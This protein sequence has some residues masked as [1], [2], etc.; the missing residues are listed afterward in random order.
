MAV[1]KSLIDQKQLPRGLRNNN[2]GNLRITKEKWQGKVPVEKNTDKAFEQ[3][4]ELRY[5]IRAMIKL[6]INDI[7]AG[8]DTIE[9]LIKEYAP[10][11]ENDTAKYIRDVARAAK[12]PATQPIKAS[13]D[14]IGRIVRAMINKENGGPVAERWITQED[15]DNAFALIDEVVKKKFELWEVPV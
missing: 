14:I 4:F 2:P 12:V 10:P 8:K 1:T 9:K 11:N 3:F 7:L 15:I 5:G 13:K 6:I